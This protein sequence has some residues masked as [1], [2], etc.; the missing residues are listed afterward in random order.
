VLEIDDETEVI[1]IRGIVDESRFHFQS[2]RLTSSLSTGL[3][4]NEFTWTDEVQNIGGRDALM[5]MLYHF[6]IGQP[7]LRTGARI[8]APIS[9][10]APHTKV[11]AGEGIDNWN[12]M[13][14]PRPGSAEQVYVA[15]LEQDDTSNARVL[16][17]GL[18]DGEAVGLRFN[19]GS[20]PCF[21]VWRNTSAE[22]DGYVVGIEPG[23]NFPNPRTF[24]QEHGRVVTLK[25]GDK[26][27]ASVTATWYDDPQA[28]ENEVAAIKTIQSNSDFMLS[29]E[30]R[31]GWSASA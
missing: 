30:P 27:Q 24:E 18:T 15:D 12:I 20:L 31:K 11:A 22:A 29:D 4:S 8:T 9:A 3:G 14:P 25:P 1:T 13:P 10:A 21:T 5:Q 6:N 26:W 17:G 19:K 2:L 16:V 7:L 23:T 28:I